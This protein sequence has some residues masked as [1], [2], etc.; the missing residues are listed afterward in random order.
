MGENTKIEWARHTFNAWIGCTKL[1]PACDFCYAES[2]AK[3]RGWAKWG[4]GEERKLTSGANWRKPYLWDKAAKAAGERHSVFCN[5]LA[6][7]MDAEVDDGWRAKLGGVIADTPNLD[8]LLL[9]KRH[10]V[11]L[12]KLPK[13]AAPAGNIR[14]GF[15]V[16]NQPMA[17]LRLPALRTLA[18]IGYRTFVSYEPALGPVDWSPWTSDG[19]IGWLIAGGESGRHARA[20]HPDWFRSARDACAAAKVAYHFKQWGEHAPVMVD[21]L[22]GDPSEM[23]RRVGKKAAGAT[24]DDVEHRDFPR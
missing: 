1:S 2:M 5:S 15:T 17:D 3:F 10:N 19:T 16:E 4:P 22:P 8:W 7:V 18:G 9:T 11:A 14:I 23:M 13:M 6:D 24:L 12:K 20:P 21:D